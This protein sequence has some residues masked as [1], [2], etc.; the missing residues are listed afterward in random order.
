MAFKTFAV[1]SS[2]P[3][4]LVPKHSHRHKRRPRPRE[5][6]LPVPS[7]GPWKPGVCF[8]SMDLL[9]LDVFYKQSHMPLV[10]VCLLPLW[11]TVSSRSVCGIAG[12]RPLFLFRAE[13]YSPVWMDPIYLL[14]CVCTLGLFL[15]CA[16]YGSCC[17]NVLPV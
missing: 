12:V 6:S 8:L 1:L 2:H 15:L 14:I 9:V 3:R 5:R 10:L 4:S 7:P 13:S 17:S 16:C 11:T